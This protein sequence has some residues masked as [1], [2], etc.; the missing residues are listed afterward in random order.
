MECVR[1]GIS[2]KANYE[3]FGDFTAVAGVTG[4]IDGDFCFSVPAKTA[5]AISSAML[6]EEIQPDDKATITDAM[7]EMLNIIAGGAKR[8]LSETQYKF[9]M[10]LPNIITGKNHNVIHNKKVPCVLFEYT[11]NGLPFVL[12]LN[13]KTD[14]Q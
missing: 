3:M 5:T 7:A 1:T 9:D 2:L 13:F 10:S 12:Q 8:R 14:G 11:A 6:M 4:G